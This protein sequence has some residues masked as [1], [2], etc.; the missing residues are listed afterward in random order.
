MKWAGFATARLALF[1]VACEMKAMRS[2]EASRGRTEAVMGA[3]SAKGVISRAHRSERLRLAVQ[4]ILVIIGMNEITMLEPS[5][6]RRVELTPPQLKTV[7]L[8]A[9]PISLSDFDSLRLLHR[10][11]VVM[12][13]LA[14][15]GKP[16]SEE[17]TAD[18][19]VRSM[20]SWET[21]GVG[22]WVF[23][24]DYTETFIGYCGLK[25]E[26]IDGEPC[27]ELR[28]AVCAPHW[29]QGYATEMA[30]AVLYFKLIADITLP[31]VST[32]SEGDKPAR[33]VIEKLGFV[34]DKVIER[35]GRN[36]ELFRL[37]R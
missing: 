34:F 2:G 17:E 3:F 25:P 9:H 37:K 18:M 10:D 4:A 1:R 11:P 36:H 29:G 35:G 8:T 33:H 19:I 5:E 26:N 21:K 7:R 28:Y 27:F 23:E 15:T 16:W 12:R 13:T 30:R 24:L 20:D 32:V 14:P 22:P 31:I 6:Q